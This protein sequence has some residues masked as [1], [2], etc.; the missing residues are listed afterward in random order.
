MKMNQTTISFD[1][2]IHVFSFSIFL[3]I[4]FQNLDKIYIV[5]FVPIIGKI[6]AKQLILV[7]GQGKFVI[8]Q[9]RPHPRKWNFTDLRD[10]LILEERLEQQSVLSDNLA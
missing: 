10:V 4:L 2:K 8:V 5:E 9:N 7:V 3:F 6:L 1:S